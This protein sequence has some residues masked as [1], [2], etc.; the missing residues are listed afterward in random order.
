MTRPLISIIVP[1]FNQGR[2]IRQTIQSIL[3]QSYSPFE[4]LVLDGKSDDDTV[5]VLRSFTADRRVRWWSEADDGVAHAVNKGLERASGEIIGIQ[6]SDDCYLPAAFDSAAEAF[7]S[8]DVGLVY[9]DIV[10]VDE[11]GREIGRTDL[12]PFSLAAFL[13]KVTWIPQPSAFFRAD[14]GRRVGGWNPEYF[15]ADTEFWLRL[16]FRTRVVKLNGTLGVR[17]QHAEQR[18]RQAS[19]IVESYTRMIESSPDVGA[20]SRALKRAARCGVIVHGLRYGTVSSLTESWRLWKAI[21]YYPPLLFNVP[22]LGALVPGYLPLR[23]KIGA[24][25]RTL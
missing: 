12:P 19:A 18:N 3:A 7:T 14:L 13:A 23:G 16:A 22:F 2:F 5:D 9:G 1:S 25:W 24:L 21:A 20:A 11:G 10:T 8:G 17:R 15:N 6:S 4:V